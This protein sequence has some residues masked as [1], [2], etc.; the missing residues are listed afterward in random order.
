MKPSILLLLLL[1][2]SLLHA[3]ALTADTAVRF[4]G[5]STLHDFEGHAAAEP[6]TAN[7]SPAPTGGTLSIPRIRFA[8]NSLSTDHTKRDANMMRMLGPAAHPDITGQIKD[9]N[10]VPGQPAR[11]TL[12]LTL[13]GVTHDLP[14]NILSVSEDAEGLHLVCEFSLSLKAFSLRRPSVLGVIRVGDTVTLHTETTLRR[15]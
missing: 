7:W 15:P 8:A 1:A 6:A 9:W 13:N 3:E 11:E 14:V 5:T 12:T 2:P 10:L 4:N